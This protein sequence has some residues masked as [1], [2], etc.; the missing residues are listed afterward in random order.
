MKELLIKK[1]SKCGATVEVLHDC[2]CQDCGIVCCGVL[3]VAMRPNTVDASFEKHIPNY[4]V[5]ENKI[6]AT[7]NHVME[8][9]HYI[10]WLALVTENQVYKRV[11]QLSDKPEAVFP[12]VPNSKL[13]SYCN[14]HG[15]WVK[16]V[17]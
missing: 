11:L 14:K 9:E 7:V 4:E 17:E 13:Y 8:P 15:L 2:S 6:L 1:C 5:Q 10:E 16:D 12:Y 3:M